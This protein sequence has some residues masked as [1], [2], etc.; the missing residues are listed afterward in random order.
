M[1][2]RCIGS[3][4]R[5][6]RRPVVKPRVRRRLSTDEWE[7]MLQAWGQRDFTAGSDARSDSI[8]RKRAS[9]GK[10]PGY[11]GIRG[12]GMY[13]MLALRRR[14]L[15]SS[16]PTGMAGRHPGLSPAYSFSR[17]HPALRSDAGC[18]RMV[19]RLSCSGRRPNSIRASRPPSTACSPRRTGRSSY[20]PSSGTP[21]SRP[22]FQTGGPA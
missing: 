4:P 3:R 20:P 21:C 19:R 5:G 18:S 8:G 14:I 10:A 22:V 7:T 15:C 2:Q 13:A 9:S 16:S 17:V 11:F 12:S 6:H 1:G